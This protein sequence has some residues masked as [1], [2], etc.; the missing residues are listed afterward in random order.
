MTEKNAI[1]RAAPVEIPIVG[2]GS[3]PV[4]RIFCVGRNYEAHAR[5]MGF[6]SERDEPI[7]F[8]KPADAIVLDGA[9]IPYP[10]MTSDY[11]HEVEL[12]VALGAGGSEIPVGE[13][14]GHVF[15]Y[16]VGLDMTRRDVQLAAR[17]QGLPWDMSKAFD[18][19]APCGTILPAAAAGEIGRAGIRLTVNGKV[20]QSSNLAHLIWSVEEIV[21]WLSRY[22]DLAAGDLIY[23]GTPE[24]VGPVVAGDLLHAEV[25]GLP[26][27]T[28]SIA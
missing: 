24:G 10:R 2:G 9:S 27:L 25:D 12:V 6:E 1:A 14:A 8:T 28:V 11:H 15:G 18:R 3:F 22:V 7:F 16:A 17:K 23:T 26:P 4:R 21:H 13:A 20:R 19:S 5:E